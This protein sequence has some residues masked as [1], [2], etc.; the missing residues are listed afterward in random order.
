MSLAET[1]GSRVSG[2]LYDTLLDLC[3]AR[4]ALGELSP[5]DVNAAMAKLLWHP[6]SVQLPPAD[7]I[8]SHPNAAT[9][10]PELPPQP[11]GVIAKVAERPL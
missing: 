4:V 1:R 11:P 5:G 2:E 10:V 6:L 9:S 7:G 3:L 8:A